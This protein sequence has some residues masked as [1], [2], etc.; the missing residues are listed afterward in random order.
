MTRDIVFLPTVH[1]G[2]SWHR[3]SKRGVSDGSVSSPLGPDLHGC[4]GWDVSP[5]SPQLWV[6][7]W[8]GPFPLLNH[9]AGCV[10]S[11]QFPGTK[12]SCLFDTVGTRAELF[13][14]PL[15]AVQK[16]IQSKRKSFRRR[17]LE[18]RRQERLQ[19]RVTPAK[20]I[21]HGAPSPVAHVGAPRPR[22]FYGVVSL[23]VRGMVCKQGPLVHLQRQSMGVNATRVPV[24]LLGICL[25]EAP[26]G[27]ASTSSSSWHVWV[28]PVR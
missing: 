22:F 9:P 20:L 17:P 15:T 26:P 28:K 13:S 14:P 7:R 16:G 1:C 24:V 3:V 23:R 25:P 19:G 10:T 18:A 6:W 21:I 12:V 8:S 4:L 27:L 11:G 5:Q 2:K